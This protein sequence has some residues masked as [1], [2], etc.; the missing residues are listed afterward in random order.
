MLISLVLPPIINFLWLSWK[1]R[2]AL[3]YTVAGLLG[4]QDLFIVTGYEAED[5]MVASI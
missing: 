1:S 3:K 2:P 4:F 5:P